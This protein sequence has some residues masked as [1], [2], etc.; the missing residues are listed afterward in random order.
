MILLDLPKF[1]SD[2]KRMFQIRSSWIKVVQIGSKKIKNWIKLGF[3]DLPKFGSGGLAGA[4]SLPYPFLV[5]FDYWETWL[6]LVMLEHIQ[7]CLK[8]VYDAS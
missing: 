1:R 7:A 8:Q 2:T 6:K 3:I 5:I 4:C